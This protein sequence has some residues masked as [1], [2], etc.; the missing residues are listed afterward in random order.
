MMGQNRGLGKAAAT[1]GIEQGDG[2]VPVEGGADLFKVDLG[3]RLGRL[4]HL[5]PEGHPAQR[6]RGGAS[7]DGIEQHHPPQQ[8]ESRT[9]ELRRTSLQLG[10][11][12]AKQSRIVAGTKPRDGN[13]AVQF[14]AGQGVGQ[15]LL[16]IAGI[17]GHQGDADA[18]RGQLQL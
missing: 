2:V 5:L 12:L 7:I 1:G 15:L 17:D 14:R 6:S 18:G 8:G 11:Q 13:Q 3:D 16:P 10:D 9:V 4:Q